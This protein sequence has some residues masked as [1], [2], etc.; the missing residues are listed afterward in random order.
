VVEALNLE[1]VIELIRGALGDLVKEIT[2][3]KGYVEVV[4]NPGDVVTAATKL[5][6]LGFDHVKSVTAVDYPKESKIRVTYHVSSYLRDDLARVIVGLS[7]DLSRENPVMDSLVGVWRSS[8]FQEREVYEFF[9][10]VF[11]GHPDLRPLLLIPELAEKR[12]LRKDFIV[13]E[14]SIY[15]GVPH[16]YQ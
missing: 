5:K 10:V 14:E 11:K 2:V 9:G 7:V 8:E 12:V 3:R 13:R 16:R 6:E 15:E 4:V 1:E